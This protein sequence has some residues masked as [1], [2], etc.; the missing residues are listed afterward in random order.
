VRFT[1]GDVRVSG[2]A[3]FMLAKTGVAWP[4]KTESKQRLLAAPLGLG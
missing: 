2:S 3:T 4:L 1:S